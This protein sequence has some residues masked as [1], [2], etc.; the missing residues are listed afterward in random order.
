[1]S[2]HA[3]H[4]AAHE[5]D[6]L[7]AFVHD[8]V[9]QLLRLQ[10]VTSFASSSSIP[11]PLSPS[12]HPGL[13]PSNPHLPARCAA[14]HTTC[15]AMLKQALAVLTPLSPRLARL[16][17]QVWDLASLK[18]FALLQLAHAAL[19]ENDA[20]LAQCEHAARF[21]AESSVQDADRAA[22]VE[23]E[24]EQL[25]VEAQQLRAELHTIKQRAN[26]LAVEKTQLRR[27]LSSLLDGP[28]EPGSAAERLPNASNGGGSRV[29]NEFV[30]D[31]AAVG[32]AEEQELYGVDGDAL[33]AVEVAHPLERAS[34][35][36]DQVLG[37]LVEGEARHVAVLNDMD[38]F[39]NSNAVG[40]LWRY[41]STE[42]QHQLME[43]MLRSRHASTQTSGD[44]VIV[45]RASV[46]HD[47]AS[48]D[49]TDHSSSDAEK[50]DDGD[51]GDSDVDDD[52]PDALA[53]GGVSGHAAVVTRTRAIPPTLRAQLDSRPK[54]H[55]VL[56]LRDVA[57]LILALYVDKLDADAATV[58]A[59]QPRAPLHRFLK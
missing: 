3:L 20:L 53:S 10:P 33:D 17:A 22:R 50:D 15:A 11:P 39:I 16:V 18:V 49:K 31:V 5:L 45:R 52:D 59:Q 21:Q 44:V 43:R 48:V 27:V 34:A 8:C 36:L 35:D 42:Q 51:D 56:E 46:R 58:R 2:G 30:E 57:Q 25:R 41:G 38:R 19:S 6:V 24:R 4:V 23:R 29:V 47:R 54:I 37:A 32:S 28:L 13:Q 9:Q 1:M 40:L 7:E 14:Y 12:K 26:R 55:R